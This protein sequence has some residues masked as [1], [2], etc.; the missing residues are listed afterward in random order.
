MRYADVIPQQTPLC[1]IT[2]NQSGYCTALCSVPVLVPIPTENR[3]SCLLFIIIPTQQSENETCCVVRFWREELV[4]HAPF[5]VVENT[6]LSVLDNIVSSYISNGVSHCSSKKKTTA[7]LQYIIP[8][9]TNTS[10][11]D[12]KAEEYEYQTRC[13][14]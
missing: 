12:A 5:L 6:I 3:F 9:E 4:F 7:R 1:V 10:L 8:W 13:T 2:F 11:S 14:S